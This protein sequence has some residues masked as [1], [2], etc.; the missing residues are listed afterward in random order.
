[1]AG[2]VPLNPFVAINRSYDM[3]TYRKRIMPRIPAPIKTYCEGTSKYKAI[4]LKIA[5]NTE[6][7]LMDLRLPA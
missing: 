6:R 2:R 4:K 7:H 5:R 1:M 3:V